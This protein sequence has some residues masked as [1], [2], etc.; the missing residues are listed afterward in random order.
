[1]PIEQFVVSEVEA[2]RSPSYGLST[3]R[4]AGWG[5]PWVLGGTTSGGHGSKRDGTKWDTRAASPRFGVGD[6]QTN[7]GTPGA[8]TRGGVLEFF[9]GDGDGYGVGYTVGYGGGYGG[10]CEC[11]RGESREGGGGCKGGGGDGSGAGGGGARGGASSS[12]FA[13]PLIHI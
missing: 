7:A 5:D 3:S 6:T 1:M 10:G 9:A 8:T 4:V 13:L 12:S 2:A 11:G